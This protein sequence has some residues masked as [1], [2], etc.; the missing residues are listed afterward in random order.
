MVRRADAARNARNPPTSARTMIRTTVI[1]GLTALV[2]DLQQR[3]QVAQMRFTASKSLRDQHRDELTDEAMNAFRQRAETLRK[4]MG[5][6]PFRIV[7]LEILDGAQM[8]RVAR[9]DFAM[10]S[11]QAD[12]PPPA[13]DAG[14]SKMTVTVTGTVQYGE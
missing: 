9:S 10:A 14:T 8:P 1:P 13:V 11:A 4:H 7:E 5:D 12:A 2:G 3:L 6:A